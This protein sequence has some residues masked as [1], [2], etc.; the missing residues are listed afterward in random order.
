LPQTL[1]HKLQLV[2]Y[3]DTV[4]NFAKARQALHTSTPSNIFCRDKELAVIENFM[5]PLIEMSKP[6]SMYISG[7]PGTGKTACVTHI[8]SNCRNVSV[9]SLKR[10]S[11]V[12]LELKFFY[13]FFVIQFSGKFKSIFINCMLLHTPSSIFQQIAQQLDP[14]WSAVAKEA[15]SF[16]ED[17]LTESGPMM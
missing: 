7:R 3:F 14:K 9:L 17:K 4:T 16:L 1:T 2:I 5:R 11:L 15:L 8:L 12:N 6:G 10:I 13:N